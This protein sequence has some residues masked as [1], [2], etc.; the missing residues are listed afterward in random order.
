MKKVLVTGAGSGFGKLYTIELAKRGY[1]VYAGVEIASQI[2]T[3]KNT[4]LENNLKAN[5]FKL[6]IC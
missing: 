2:T 4:L 5:V 3:L 6:D 1:D